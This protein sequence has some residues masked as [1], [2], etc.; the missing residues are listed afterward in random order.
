MVNLCT[1]NE[2]LEKAE[3]C[4]GQV[5]KSYHFL[6]INPIKVI[7]SHKD[8]ELKNYVQ[9][10]DIVYPDAI[11]ICLAVRWL[12]KIEQERIPGYEFHFDVLKICEK[13]NY[14]IYIVGA[15]EKILKSSIKK[16]KNKYPRLIFAGYN[17]GYFSEEYFNEKILNDIKQLKPHLVLV[18]MGAKLQEKYIEIIRSN[19]RV[20]LLMGI[21][22]SLDAFVGDAPRAPKWLLDLGLE[23][24]YRLIMQPWRYRAMLPLPVFAFKIIKKYIGV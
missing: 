2:L 16:Y 3:L 14:S 1:K 18:A 10:A 13:K 9:K 20:P 19:A 11:G 12:Y 21:G 15:Q 6:S 5:K 7:K 22:G 8:V 23:W 4:L 24:F 17:N